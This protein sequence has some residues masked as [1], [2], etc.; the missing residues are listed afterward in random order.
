[1]V[2][3]E[4]GTFLDDEKTV[5]CTVCGTP[6]NKGPQIIDS[7]EAIREGR[8]AY[9]VTKKH[10]EEQKDSPS[11]AYA[12]DELWDRGGYLPSKISSP[13]VKSVEYD[14]KE[15]K[16][17]SVNWVHRGIILSVVF[18]I[19]VAGVY[20]FFK[21]T[22]PGQLILARSFKADK[23][24][25]Y[26]MV[27]DEFADKGD[28]VN[29]IR[30]YTLADSKDPNNADG[31]LSLASIYEAGNFLSQA[32]AIYMRIINE[33]SPNRPEPYRALSRMLVV[34]N[35][36]PEA[37]NI[38]KLAAENT[39][40]K[41]FMDQRTEML[42]STPAVDLPGGRYNS[43][44]SINL[45]SS[46]GYEIYYVINNDAAT[47]PQDGV[48][49]D[50]KPIKIPEGN[51]KIRAVST[52]INLV[53]D[54]LVVSY[55]IIYPSPAAPYVHLAPGTYSKPKTVAL[56]PGDDNKDVVIYYTIDGSIPTENSPIYDGTPIKLPSGRVSIK[57]F[58]KNDRGKT[59]STREVGYKIDVKP[60]LQKL[61]NSEDLFNGIKL[62]STTSDEFFTQFG[63]AESS[64]DIDYSTLIKTSAKRY[65]YPW[66]YADF[67]LVS[68][69]WVLAALEM[70]S[71]ITAEPRGVGF[72]ATEEEIVAQFKDMGQAPNL[73][74]TRGL[75][76]NLPDVGRI[77][78]DDKGTRYIQYACSSPDNSVW[79]LEYYLKDGVVNRIKHYYLP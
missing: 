69:K 56:S 1:M 70:N 54:P 12:N 76:Y 15:A 26:W 36:D 30:A 43:E 39:G 44:K 29:A 58:S 61:Y 73:D 21:Q 5:V 57:A 72:G 20:L 42:P 31:L 71:K 68:N 60:Y 48:L 6:L 53:S 49:Y 79:V 63:R 11:R 37:A 55:I 62:Y 51:I 23:A 8:E 46:E 9:P 74:G 2:C 14:P 45:S 28:I 13:T 64:Q 22:E 40:I 19:I 59:S 34:Q 75:Y 35:R 77:L 41:S 52:S 32:E 10:I 17:R 3:P 47:L 33:I 7:V 50:G 27:G 16:K 25:A 66:G 38:L 65:N 18:I 67:I 4:C 78:F 24:Q